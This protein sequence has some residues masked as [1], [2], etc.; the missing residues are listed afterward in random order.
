MKRNIYIYILSFLGLLSFSCKDDLEVGNQLEISEGSTGLTLSLQV[1]IPEYRTRAIDMAPGGSL[2]LN[3]IWIGVYNKSNGKRVVSDFVN[4]HSRLTESGVTLTD[5]IKISVNKW[6]DNTYGDYYCIVGVAN[7][8]GIK[9]KDTNKNLIDVLNDA[10][11]WS[12]FI[13]ISIDTQQIFSNQTPLLMGYLTETNSDEKKPTFINQFVNYG[14]KIQISNQS[15]VFISGKTELLGTHLIGFNQSLT[16]S[17]YILRLH[18]LISKNNIRINP[19]NGI[20]VTNVEY[21]VCNQ[22]LSS[23]LAERSTNTLN[24]N[25]TSNQYSANSS[26]VKEEGYI[27]GSW[28]HPT[29]NYN[30]SFEHFENKHWAWNNQSIGSG[31][32]E[33]KKRYHE[34]EAKNNY[35]AFSAL[36][37]SNGDANHWNNNA[38]YFILKMNIKDENLGRNGEVTYIIHEGF[39]NDANGNQTSDFETRMKDFSCVR[40]T[41]YYYD[42]K[43][44]SIDDIV[45]SVQ[46]SKNHQYD[47][48]GS[49]WQ[50]TYVKDGSNNQ[51]VTDIYKDGEPQ[52]KE[53]PANLSLGD[54]EKD[55]IAIRLVGTFFDDSNNKIDVDVCYN[56]A[57]GDLDGFAG[58]WKEP[59]SETT[60]Y[61]VTTEDEYDNVTTAYQAFESFISVGSSNAI[62]F[63]LLANK[64]KIKSA[65]SNEY[66]TIADYIKFL[67]DDSKT[68]SPNISGFMFEGYKFY[69]LSD[70]SERDYLRALYIFDK[71][72]ALKTGT[73]IQNDQWF[74]TVDDPCNW[75]YEITGVEQYA[76]YLTEE[77]F[78]RKDASVANNMQNN[79]VKYPG[80]ETSPITN[81]RGFNDGEGMVFS[82]NP[83]LAFRLL[84][85]DGDNYYDLCYNFDTKDY[86]ALEQ[87]S[88]WAMYTQ[89]TKFIT[90]GGLSDEQ[91][92]TSLLEGI[93]LKT[94]NSS[95]SYDIKSFINLS[96]NGNLQSPYDIRFVLNTYDKKIITLNPDKYKRALYIFDKK[97]DKFEKPV[98]LSNDG[99]TAYYQ[100]YAVEQ[101]P[102][103]IEPEYL[104]LPIINNF[105]YNNNTIYNQTASYEFIE[106]NIGKLSLPLLSSNGVYNQD[107]Y[108]RLTVGEKIYDV[109]TNPS[110][111]TVN[112]DVPMNLISSSTNDVY[113]EAIAIS[114]AY[115]DSQNKNK[116]GSISPSGLTKMTWDFTSNNFISHVQSYNNWTY[117]EK[118]DTYILQSESGQTVEDIYNLL[119]MHVDGGANMQAYYN[120]DS[121]YLY[122]NNTGTRCSLNIKIYRNCKIQV[123][124][125]PYIDKNGVNEGALTVVGGNPQKIEGITSQTVCESLIDLKDQEYKE[126]S[127]YFSKKGN[128]TKVQL[129]DP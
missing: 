79:V 83:D 71:Q 64:I 92:P 95:N 76:S 2:Y 125:L 31:I 93:K 54:A 74:H 1:D 24:N 49:V 45:V 107:Y 55:D 69:Q 101:Y 99:K 70:G 32:T 85:Y 110:N 73:K 65:Y 53:I 39:C 18:R 63:Q 86:P 51:V 11:N 112:F 46:E 80:G 116:I 68:F 25:S 9:T 89:D 104:Q 118:N 82:S 75:F 19:V 29:D 117:Y 8:D 67:N 27:N 7:Y 61:L 43:I 17:N 94:D 102:N 12:D 28:Q 109:R 96:D 14:D 10:E 5:I 52:T 91:I 40:N 103:Y 15:N 105:R 72:K 38:S 33:E 50:I 113:L 100:L 60:E 57:R 16:N 115:L 88:L 36:V 106:E 119:N 58:L 34:R 124:V 123:T 48:T 59:S 23:F 77:V 127:I 22:P 30:F 126:V 26:D 56:F 111:S 6:I 114:E 3:N 37:G 13:N 4:L 21:Q 35:G 78:E 121:K 108:Y 47:Q 120:G 66:I 97:K 90:K 87:E 128:I 20:T 84:G 98:L 41:D 42:I 129:L 62:N 44:N 81:G 122:F